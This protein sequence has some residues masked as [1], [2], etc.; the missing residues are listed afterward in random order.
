MPNVLENVYPG[1][2]GCAQTASIKI[3]FEYD[4]H[5]GQFLNFQVGPGKNTDK[6]FGTLLIPMR[7]SPVLLKEIEQVN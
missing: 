5:S 3:Q 4:L 6:T 2:G 7:F 1:S